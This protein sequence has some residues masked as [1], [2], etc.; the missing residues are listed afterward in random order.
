MSDPD[1]IWKEMAQK[2]KPGDRVVPGKD[3]MAS[4]G[5]QDGHGPGTITNIY[6]DNSLRVRW[7]KSGTEFGYRMGCRGKYDLKIIDFVSSNPQK[8]IGKSLGSLIFA[9]EE[10]FD[11]KFI[12]NGK[13]FQCHKIVLA[14]QSDVFK[15][16]FLNMDMTEA[17]SGEVK[18]NDFTAETI[19]TLMYYLYNQEVKDVSLINTDLLLVAE[20]YNISSLLEMCS[21]HL[22][23]N[24]SPTN[25]L[26]VL[27]TAHLT[28]Q[29]GLF[30]AASKFVSQNIGKLNKTTTAWKEMNKTNPIMI[31]NILSS[32]LDV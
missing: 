9:T 26:D 21:G 28:N 7:D 18:I 2:M 15:T 1:A 24:L 23:S 29:E 19:E 30:S 11:L 25:A 31:K 12:C 8:S 4:Y 13:T 6:F 32:V 10:F 3:W 22:Q 27:L 17:K 14:S 20:K 5:D 16:M